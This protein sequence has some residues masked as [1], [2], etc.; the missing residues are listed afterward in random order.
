MKN[1]SDLHLIYHN[2]SFNLLRGLIIHYNM[3]KITKTVWIATFLAISIISFYSCQLF[4]K[5]KTNPV[6][7]SVTNDYS[8]DWHIVDS[9]EQQGLPKSA[10]EKVKIIADRA[11]IEN[12]TDQLLK[13]IIYQGKY[14]VQLE[15]DGLIKSVQL[16]ESEEKTAAQPA[17]SLLQSMLGQLYA[18]YLSSN[19]WQL[20]QR[21]PI[22]DGE[23]GDILTW[24]AAQIE[25]RAMD[26]YLASVAQD[27]L[28]FATQTAAWKE[29]IVKGDLDSIGGLPLRP[30]LFDLLAHRAIEH[31]RN[32]RSYLTEPAYRFNLDQSAAFAE[33]ETFAKTTFASKDS[34]S[35]KWRTLQ[36]FQKLT[37]LRLTQ[38]NKAPLVVLTL[39]R[40]EFVR[41]NS[42]LSD[43][44]TLYSDALEQLATRWKQDPV[45]T[46][47]YYNQ[48][49]L[50][51]QTA[52][53]GKNAQNL[54][55]AVATCKKAIQRFPTSF[56]AEQCR[57]LL[58]QLEAKELKINV[59]SY[60]IP[61]QPILLST[62]FKNTG[63]LNYKI[64]KVPFEAP[65]RIENHVEYALSH[66]VMFTGTTNLTDPG[67]LKAH[68]TE[69]MLNPLPPGKYIV[70]VGPDNV[71]EIAKSVTDY[72]EFICTD[73]ATVKMPVQEGYTDIFLVNRSTGAP[74]SGIIGEVR[75]IYWDGNRYNNKN[76]GE[77]TTDANGKIRV[78]GAADK[79]FYVVFKRG[80]DE[81]ATNQ[82][83]NYTERPGREAGEIAFFTD[84]GIYRPGQ[85]VYF[86][87]IVMHRDA[88]R[89]PSIVSNEPVTVV[90]KDANNQE[91]AKLSLK[92]NEFGSVNGTFTIPLGTL[93]GSF[94]IQATA[95]ISHGY[96]NIQ[97]EEYKRPKFEVTFNQL[98]GSYRLNK[99]VTTTGTAMNYAGNPSD[100]SKVSWR[101][102]RRTWYPWWWG[103]YMPGYGGTE[104][105]I[106]NG[107][108]ITA[109]DGTFKIAFKAIPGDEPADEQPPAYQYEILADITDASGETRSGS[110]MVSVGKYGVMLGNNLEEE[111]IQD[112]LKSV[113]LITNNL[114]DKK[115]A[116]KGK[117]SLQKLAAPERLF[118]ERQFE[119]PDIL[120]MTE[121]DFRKNFPNYAW[122]GEDK[123][124][125]WKPTGTPTEFN[126][127][128]GLSETL[129]LSTL[130]PGYYKVVMTANDP[131]GAPV[132]NEKIIRIKKSQT[133][134]IA[135]NVFVGKKT[136]EPGQTATYS[137]GG[138]AKQ[139]HALLLNVRP[140]Q[141]LENNWT[142]FEGSQNINLPITEKDRGDAW[143]FWTMV[144]D[145]RVYSGNIQW[146]VPWSNKQLN[147]TFETFRDKLQPG[148]KEEWRIR[149]SGPGKEKVAA[150]M[151]AS[152]YDASLDQFMPFNWNF[153]PYR[154]FYPST[155][156]SAENFG[157]IAGFSYLPYT[158]EEAVPFPNRNFPALNWFDFPFYGGGYRGRMMQKTMAMP[159]ASAVYDMEAMDSDGKQDNY[160][161]SEVVAYLADSSGSG[162]GPVPPPP[163]A[164]P[165]PAPFR[166]NLAETVFF[167]PEMRTD[168]NGDI[169]LKFKMNEALTRWKLQLFAHSKDLK[170]ALAEKTVVTQKDLMITANAPRFFRT[171]DEIEFAAKITNLTENATTGKASLM[172]L[173]AETLK[174]IEKVMGLTQPV[175]D[176]S[177]PA[178]QSTAVR[179]K[180]KIPTDYTGAVTW[181]VFADSKAGRDGEES[182]VPVVT[183]RMLVT[184]TL[185]MALR[186]NQSKTFRFDEWKPSAT[187]TPVRYTLEFTSNPAWY[188]VQSLPYLMEYPHECSEQVFSRF[189]ANTLASSVTEKMP[190]I[191]RVFDRW[192]GTK[193]LESNLSK[194]QEL[195]YAILEETPWVMDAQNE[196]QQK[197]NIALLFDLNRMTDERQKALNTLVERQSSNGGWPWFTGGQESWYITQYIVC[198]L[199]HLQC[200]EAFDVKKD[201]KI[202]NMLDKALGYCQ[203]QAET[204]YREIEKN[205][206]AGKAKWDDDHLDGLVIQYLYA[207]S[208]HPVD[209]PDKVFSFYK[210]LIGKYWKSKN[211]YQQGLLALIEH[212]TGDKAVAQQIVQSLKERA[213][214]KEELGMYWPNQWGMYWYQLP[215]ETQALMVEVFNE[216]AN[217]REAVDNLRIW[218]L[219]NKQTNRWESTKATAEAVYALLLTG[220]NWLNTTK[221]VSVQ[222]GGQEVKPVEV[223][224]GSG[225]FK[226][227]WAGSDIKSSWNEVKVQN[228]NSTIVWGAAYRQYFE[229]L[230]NITTFKSTGLTLV[231]QVYR[232]KNS[233]TGPVLEL[234]K[235]GETVHT[236]DQLKVRV[237]I[238]ADRAMEFVHLKDLRPAG[239]EPQNVLS[240][241]RYNGGL[242]YYE[243]TRDLATHFFIDYLPRGTFVL[244]YPLVATHKGNMSFGLATLQCMYAPEF[245]SHS[246][247][248]R[249]KID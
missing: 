205:V 153:G 225:Y 75:E 190:A 62:Y 22:P 152:M 23:G 5:Q 142:A 119:T 164:A 234:L 227:T 210:N 24:S 134:F 239:C 9:L 29:I 217:D 146:H 110:S 112:S 10:L 219:K 7:M 74:L 64:V 129:N 11:R 218:M 151:A 244:E 240:G 121:A 183:N 212:R 242:G 161:K 208:F 69:I 139:L 237:E 16:F 228:P 211:L 114:A 25:R 44:T 96:A 138:A 193:A 192:K 226:N 198:G 147:V 236:G 181:Q 18:T 136:L 68:R 180:L 73:M 1:P 170:Y 77:L 60:N 87:G 113:K 155:Q 58:A 243:S 216:V 6:T 50:L 220:D 100:G 38:E 107:E 39:Q 89:M 2:T 63:K 86:K 59:E 34:L 184:E 145:N 128:T 30:T 137:L 91:K 105:E 229:D 233:D 174:P 179:W 84:R 163:G 157:E 214:V 223:E 195:K 143:T 103:R 20:S 125:K 131:F 54:I 85:V 57:A 66:K 21:S 249:I 133:D 101:V 191:R 186:G 76:G 162:G 55:Q 104:Q 154:N 168:A 65:D 36:L 108:T 144:Y 111:V 49:E 235:E 246:S 130:L 204:Q 93:T 56:G 207:R 120:S 95:G 98:E 115:I 106:G 248:I 182:T 99:T 45:V 241:Y 109:A 32:D 232:V 88:K 149:V 70:L 197:Q 61:G 169:I 213:M 206:Q 51:Q 26:Y 37:Q 135:P 78:R 83:Q 166:T 230:D 27:E 167:F 247:G 123:P 31:L 47:V 43:K 13:S 79:N 196:A 185:P 4:T 28:L 53:D 172:L 80:A 158:N 40:L 202:A 173:D 48:A 238:R 224:A 19:G 17:K 15:E 81:Y 215:I 187:R 140:D 200:L 122:N 189:Y 231:R 148:S 178:G 117:I 71:P 222:L 42:S 97:V 94:S 156:L 194:N 126:F 150:E 175:A 165:Y 92:S 176:F 159:A 118:R 33:P 90:F 201:Q 199:E 160:K 127:D 171:G 116:T 35:G 12:N 41:T 46:E 188:A 72:A 124:E 177:I 245:S 52:G 82:S 221:Q 141:P 203:S 3:K 132:K 102:V 14:T 8:K 67:D 209:K